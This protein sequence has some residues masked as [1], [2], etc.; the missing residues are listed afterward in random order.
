MK[1]VPICGEEGND[2][3]MRL[4]FTEFSQDFDLA[5]KPFPVL[6]FQLLDGKLWAGE[7]W[8]SKVVMVLVNIDHE[9]ASIPALVSLVMF[10]TSFLAPS[11]ALGRVRID[12]RMG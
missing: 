4:A 1:F 5:L 12:G 6:G 7:A 11:C 8:V 2:M 9:N 3:W 10:L